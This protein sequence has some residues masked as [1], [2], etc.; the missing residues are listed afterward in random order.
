M[1]LSSP[2]WGFR[3]ELNILTSSFLLRTQTK[4]SVRPGH[5]HNPSRKQQLSKNMSRLSFRKVRSLGSQMSGYSTE[6]R[7]RPGA[8]GLLGVDSSS[9]IWVL[10]DTTSE[11]RYRDS[12]TLLDQVVQILA[13]REDSR[14]RSVHVAVWT[15]CFDRVHEATTK[16][17]DAPGF[18]TLWHLDILSNTL[19]PCAKY[20]P[21]MDLIPVFDRLISSEPSLQGS[22][23]FCQ[24]SCV[25]VISCSISNSMELADKF[26]S[27]CCKSGTSPLA[28]EFLAMDL[29]QQK[30]QESTRAVISSSRL[31]IPPDLEMDYENLGLNEISLNY[32]TVAVG[33]TFDRV[34]AGHRLLLGA[35]AMVTNKSVFVGITSDKLLQNKSHRD[36]LQSYDFRSKSAV[37]YMENVNPKIRVTPGPLTDPLEP[38]L[39][40]TEENFNAIVVSEETIS[41][42]HEINRVRRGLGFPPLVIIVVGLLYSHAGNEGSK[43]SSS[44]LRVLESTG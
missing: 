6:E 5:L 35:T 44:D 13:S 8:T 28:T 26:V 2:R 21:M 29:G 27:R 3:A 1:V 16:K 36:K 9:S 23:G 38:P 40:A 10:F 17:E 33:G 30:Q 32:S 18:P 41:G 12:I 25:F 7:K 11:E 39:C 15:G 14:N 37:S 34:H 22:D 20:A 43:L 42:A 31:I 24:S 19:Y 4:C